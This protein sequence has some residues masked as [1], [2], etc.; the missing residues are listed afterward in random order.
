MSSLNIVYSCLAL[1]MDPHA[2]EWLMEDVISSTSSMKAVCSSIA[3]CDLE[4]P[5]AID[6]LQRCAALIPNT[7]VL[8]GDIPPSDYAATNKIN[9]E[10]I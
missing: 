4:L 10:T 3:Q 6:I 1:M 8:C 9:L 5:I 2:D 7:N